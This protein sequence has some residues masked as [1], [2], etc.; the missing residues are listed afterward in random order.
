MI[1]WQFQWLLCIAKSMSSRFRTVH[2]WGFRNRKYQYSKSQEHLSLLMVKKH[3]LTARKQLVLC[4]TV[5]P[6]TATHYMQIQYIHINGYTNTRI[7]SLYTCRPRK[8]SRLKS[9][10]W[11]T[12]L[13][14]QLFHVSFV[15]FLTPSFLSLHPLIKMY[16]WQETLYKHHMGF[17]LP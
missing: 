3:T 10:C 1:L 13:V 4:K 17:V 2:C 11:L 7:Y 14:W 16:Y 15:S 6:M 5:L 12:L 8:I 9:I